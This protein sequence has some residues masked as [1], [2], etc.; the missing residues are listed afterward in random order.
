M[1]VGLVETTVP[2]ANDIIMGEF[3]AYANYGLNTQVLLGATRD[4]CKI[5]IERVIKEIGFDGAMG[6]TLDTDGIPLVRYEKLIGR[7]TINN[8]YLKY[9]NRK[10]IS[11][12]ES[13]GTWE[14]GDWANNGGTYAAETT[15]V[16]EGDQSAKATIGT[17]EGHGIHEVFASDVD[18]TAFDNDEVSDDDDYIG[19]SIYLAAQD[20]T[21]LGET[22]VIRLA[23]HCDAEETETNFFHVNKA[24]TDFT[25][26]QWNNFK[27]KKSAFTDSASSD[28]S[29][30]K[31][32]ALTI[33][34]AAPDAEVVCYIDSI[35]LIQN[36]TNSSIVPMNGHGFTYTDETTYREFT[37]NLEIT[38]NDYLENF[39]LVGQRIDGKK[40]KI[41]LKNCLN[42]GNISL[43][44]EE[45]NE[46][47]NETQFTGHYK[48]G[49]GLTCPIELYEYVA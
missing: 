19:F 13:D 41:V 15:I 21:D 27:V 44:L 45:K 34:G 6:P 37:A 43:G 8:L 47:V 28:W 31:G 48:Y 39:T 3:K 32:V 40:V 18:L 11:T 17:T 10:R 23:F 9:F 22:A 42:D 4:G 26:N 36:Q 35:D 29:A 33:E 1:A 7:C 38:L 46:V 16:L 25:A 20:L 14:S 30:V 2:V 12:C 24:Y 5:D 49:A